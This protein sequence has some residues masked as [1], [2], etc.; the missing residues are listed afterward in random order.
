[1]SSTASFE[2]AAR[3]QIE[4]PLAQLRHEREQRVTLERELAV[5]RVKRA[6]V[7]MANAQMHA[8]LD[9]ERQRAWQA[10]QELAAKDTELQRCMQ[11]LREREARIVQLERVG[12]SAGGGPRL[13]VETVPAPAQQPA[14]CKYCK[15]AMLAGGQER[16]CEVHA[17][18][19]IHKT[20]ATS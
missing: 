14:T 8:A 20:T 5:E 16:N 19:C 13:P 12:A 4:D 3:A 15:K 17:P 10:Q 9:D 18:T 6:E 11:T 7:E 2:Q 1:M